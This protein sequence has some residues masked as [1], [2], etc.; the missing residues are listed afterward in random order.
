MSRIVDVVEIIHHEF[1][2]VFVGDSRCKGLEL[3]LFDLL[4]FAVTNTLDDSIKILLLLIMEVGAHL[5]RVPS[6]ISHT[7]CR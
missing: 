5:V 7:K 3:K 6:W 1:D 2:L 4:G